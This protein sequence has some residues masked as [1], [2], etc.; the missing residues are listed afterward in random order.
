MSVS[1]DVYHGVMKAYSIVFECPKGG[2]NINLQ[3]K[4]SKPSLSTKEVM[5][6]FGNLEICCPGEGC[7]WRGKASK[8]KVVQIDSFNWILAPASAN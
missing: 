1:H 8:T 2:H 4:L 5:T 3:R 6:M 7:G